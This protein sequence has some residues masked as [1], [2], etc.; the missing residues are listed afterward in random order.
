MTIWGIIFCVI[1]YMV[2]GLVVCWT[3][4]ELNEYLTD[5]LDRKDREMV[6]GN[7]A[8]RFMDCLTVKY[9]DKTTVYFNNKKL[10]WV[11]SA[12]EWILWPIAALAWSILEIIVY[13]R[14]LNSVN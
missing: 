10:M 11:F 1:S 13:K 9:N 6:G 7:N 5:V 12:A 8:V 2:L 14:L 3:N 4:K